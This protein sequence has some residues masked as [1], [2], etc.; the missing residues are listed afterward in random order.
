MEDK[1]KDSWERI[2]HPKTLKENII[3]ASLFSMAFE[4][5]KTSIIEKLEYFY[6][7]GLDKS[8]LI[9]SPDYKSEVLP[10]GKGQLYAS[11]NW[12]KNHD[13]ITGE[14]L[15]SFEYI[16]KCR[17]TLTHEMLSFTSK[18]VDFEVAEAFGKLTSLL[19]KIEIWWFVNLEMSIDPDAYPEDLDPEQVIPGPIWSLQMLI[20]IA[21]GPDE[22]AKKYY[23]QFVSSQKKT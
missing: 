20:N 8:G 4:M 14:D 18:G 3:V 17:N 10:L 19:R 16:K 9:V 15:E 13:A 23:D 1:I 22:E 6:S 7:D 21:L 2:L 5:L 11:L 12:L